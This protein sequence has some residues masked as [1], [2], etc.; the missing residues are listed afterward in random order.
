MTIALQDDQVARLT[1][2][3]A[4]TVGQRRYT[5]WFDQAAR[6]EYQREA[7]ALKVAVPNRFVAN[8]IEQHFRQA[9]SEAIEHQLGPEIGLRLEVD[10]SPFQS[11][12]PADAE[13]PTD[14]TAETGDAGDTG[15]AG[16]TRL[17]TEPG[18]SSD[19]PTDGQPASAASATA[20]GRGPA[21]R[22]RALGRSAGRAGRT[23]TGQPNA[24]PQVG[25]PMRHQ[26]DD[27]IVGP[28]NELAYA[29]ASR[30]ATDEAAAG[31][32]LFLHGGC[33]LGKTHL[34]QGLCRKMQ[35]H[36]PQARVLYTTG[37]RFTNEYITAVRANK[38]DAFRQRMRQLDL[39]AVDDVHFIA[40]KQATQQEFLHSFNEIELGGARVALASDSHPKLIEQFSDALVN[41]CVHGLVVQINQPDRDTRRRLVSELAGRRGLALQPGAV[42]VLAARCTGSVREIEGLLTKL[43]ALTTLGRGLSRSDEPIGRAMIDQLLGADAPTQPR[44]PVAFA[45]LRDAVAEAVGVSVKQLLGSSRQKQVVL[46]RGLVVYLA[47]ELTAM[48]F[49]EIAKAM[50]RANHSTI[51][52]AAKRLDRQMQAGESVVLPGQAE[53]TP[54]AEL[55]ERIKRAIGRSA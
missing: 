49:P 40:N 8:W 23:T 16:D 10:P 1:Q 29:A 48:S 41:R 42:D 55:V 50:G 18:Q 46:A 39:L 31:Q 54:L 19:Q 35:A 22:T 32:P 15:A 51:I 34:L 9:L 24:A 38:L 43:H 21:P 4:R 7:Q 37:E 11:A 3:L 6:F 45:E 5:M 33:G 28:S 14:A 53:A 13:N 52:T 17:A 26:L 36:S 30:L 27:F 2:Q 12:R 25:A 47:R 20:A 44:K